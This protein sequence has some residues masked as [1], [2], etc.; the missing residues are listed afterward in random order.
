MKPT[1]LYLARHGAT[2]MT[3]EDRF[4]GAMGAD[5][6]DEGRLQATRLG[7]R[8]HDEAIMG[9]YSSP[10]SRASDTA[11]IVARACGLTT[12]LRGELR[13]IGHGPWEGLTRRE[14]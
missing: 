3:A 9:I 8:L 4:S 12:V 10:L 7:E 1:R 13:E 2:Q 5:L 6:S 11:G 14:V